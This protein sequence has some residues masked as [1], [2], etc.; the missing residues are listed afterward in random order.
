MTDAVIAKVEKLA[1]K[2]G[3]RNLMFYK[4]D[5]ITPLDQDDSGE[6]AGVN[7]QEDSDEDEDYEYDDDQDDQ[8][9]QDDQ[10]YDESSIDQQEV[11]ELLADDR[12]HDLTS[13]H[14][15]PIQGHDED[16]G[17]SVQERQGG[18]PDDASDAHDGGADHEGDQ[19]R[20]QQED[21]ATVDTVAE[22]DEEDHEVD[23]DEEVI[24][25]RGDEPR[26]S[27]RTTKEPARL[28]MTESSKNSYDT[29][30]ERLHTQIAGVC[31]ETTAENLEYCHNLTAQVPSDPQDELQ[32][33]HE[34]ACFLA[35][36][37][38]D[39]N[40]GV[41]VVTQSECHGQQ[42]ILQ[43]GLKV[44]G[45]KG[46]AAST[47]EVDQLINR[48]CFE[49][50]SVKEMT[51]AERKRAMEALMFL[52]EKRDGRIK[53]RLVYNGKPTR[54]WLNRED[55][56]SPTASLESIMLLAA[57][58]AEEERDVQSYDIPNAF[59]QATLPSG[60]KDERVYMKITGVLVD[61]MCQIDPRYAD[62]VV[63]EN[64]RKVLYVR[65][66][67][68]IYGMLVAALLWYKKFRKDLE[69]K[70]FKF[71]PYDPCVAIRKWKG[72]QQTI[73]FHVDD[74]MS[75]H[76]DKRANEDL[77]KWLQDEYGKHGD[78]TKHVGKVH[79]YLGM[80]LDFT[81]PKKVKIDM[82]R[83]VA[84]MIET[85]PVKLSEDD[86]A[87]TPASDNLFTKATG[88]KARPLDKKRKEEFHTTVA[89]SLFLCKRA[90]PD[91]QPTVAWLCSRVKDSDE[92][93][94]TKLVRMMKY[95]NGTRE[96]VLT[97][98][99]DNLRVIKWY[100]DASFAVH[101]DFKSHTGATMTMGRGAIISSSRK[102]KLNTRSSTE[103]ELVGVDDI[104]VLILWT[105]LFLDWMGYVVEKNILYQD[106]K[107]SILLEQNGKKSS[108]KRTRALNIRYLFV[109]DQVEKRNLCIEYCP[110]DEMISDFMTKH[111]H[112]ARSSE[113]SERRFWASKSSAA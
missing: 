38:D 52:T 56:A 99:I 3:N 62:F 26:R 106:N 47:K 74:L 110:T 11:D 44:F 49:P 76:R 28:Q 93:E 72:Q 88:K 92:S 18:I 60:D 35:R 42:Y 9:D 83:Y 36:L 85:F 45:D 31:E 61:L 97:L 111:L 8:N 25:D 65:V 43:K 91:V 107:S 109:T 77:Y 57:I 12:R 17:N 30:R 19:D 102:Q 94:W 84:D 46:K 63:Y 33:E 5:G 82:R 6:I 39:L 16:D 108:S 4:R 78:V 64:G 90:R 21:S 10:D 13:N 40:N 14:P 55:S 1:R 48:G 95:L 37:I 80:I 73:R 112:K 69:G 24:V 7:D 15:R 27:T 70:G 105:K 89:K 86:T 53:G 75:S 2:Q 50:V 22:D 113:S 41:A 68:A 79:D 54:E 100:V 58:D 103:S 20:G 96:K 34:H 87:E 81:T 66:L 29:R 51:P 59:I 101:P 23:E 71:N 104:I 98:S 67:K 32:Y